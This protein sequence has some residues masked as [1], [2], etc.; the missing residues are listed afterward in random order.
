ML[1]LLLSMNTSKLIQEVMAQCFTMWIKCSITHAN[2]MLTFVIYKV[3]DVA[4]AM[5]IIMKENGWTLPQLLTDNMQIKASK[6]RL[7]LLYHTCA[8]YK[9]KANENEIWSVLDVAQKWFISMLGQKGIPQPFK[10]E[11][12]SRVHLILLCSE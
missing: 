7:L 4:L 1:I 9:R 3:E 6:F 5:R 12:Y 8:N 10:K 2:V 11:L